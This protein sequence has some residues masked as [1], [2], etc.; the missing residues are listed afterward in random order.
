M[1]DDFLFDGLKD[2]DFIQ[3]K[4]EPCFLLKA[5]TVSSLSHATLPHN[6]LAYD[7]QTSN[8]PSIRMLLFDR[9]FMIIMEKE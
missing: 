3:R 2:H 7:K 8:A 5:L 9:D 6:V 4:I 1:I